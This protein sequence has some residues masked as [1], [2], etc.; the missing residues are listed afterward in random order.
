MTWSVNYVLY[1]YVIYDKYKVYDKFELKIETEIRQR[2]QKLPNYLDT[3]FT[4]VKKYALKFK[5]K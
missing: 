3:E 4:D 1:N 5:K 2:I